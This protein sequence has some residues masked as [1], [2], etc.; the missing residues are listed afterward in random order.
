[1]SSTPWKWL[2][3]T[4]ATAGALLV[5]CTVPAIANPS[6]VRLS[7]IDIAEQM[8]SLPNWEIDGQR[9]YCTYQFTNFVE[10]VNFVNR[11]VEPAEA[12]GHHPDIGISYNKVMISLTTHDA[13]GL[14]LQDF[15]LARTISRLGEGS[16][17][18][19]LTCQP[20][21]SE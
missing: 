4:L 21:R 20:T 6:L 19:S 13:G 12:A 16:D 3:L 14:T 1:M 10:A 2:K 7:E 11:L 18:N 9:L 5:M 15:D 17:I 8:Q